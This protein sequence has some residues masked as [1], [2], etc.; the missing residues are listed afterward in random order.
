MDLQFINKLSEEEIISLLNKTRNNAPYPIDSI[1]VMTEDEKNGMQNKT[2][3]AC[4]SRG[5]TW[6]DGND[7][8]SVYYLNDFNIAV[9]SVLDGYYLKDDE[10]ITRIFREFMTLR[11]GE[12]YIQAFYDNELRKANE[13]TKELIS[14]LEKET[15]SRT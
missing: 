1:V 8:I 12:E 2:I 4:I 6:P 7:L 5:K 9:S 15:K 13:S 14:V 10:D 11:F 3:A